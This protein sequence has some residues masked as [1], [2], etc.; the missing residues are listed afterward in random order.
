MV[1][2]LKVV[3]ST[4]FLLGAIA[5]IGL[6]LSQD[7][8]REMIYMRAW[9]CQQFSTTTCWT[10]GYLLSLLEFPVVCSIVTIPFIMVYYEVID[11]VHVNY[12][13]ELVK[14]ICSSHLPEKQLYHSEIFQRKVAQKMK[15]CIMIHNILIQLSSDG[16]IMIY[17]PTVL[18]CIGSIVMGSSMLLFILSYDFNQLNY[19]VIGI[20]SGTVNYFI[21]V[22]LYIHFSQL[23]K[24]ESENTYFLLTQLPWYYMNKGNLKTF[25]I[26]LRQSERPISCAIDLFE[27]NYLLLVRIFKALYSVAAIIVRFQPHLQ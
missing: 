4:N 11:I 23:L 27:V 8:L 14:Q 18:I 22:W 1:K 2:L 5:C 10:S 26:I 20:F 24:N 12:L 6:L 3:M 15:I 7:T 13:N 16:T 9:I 25:S 17:V 19:F 21:C